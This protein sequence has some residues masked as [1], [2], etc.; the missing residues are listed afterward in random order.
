MGERKCV[1]THII[2]GTQRRVLWDNGVSGLVDN[3]D[4]F[5]NLTPTGRY[6]PEIAA[7]LE[8]MRGEQD[9]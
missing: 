6:F 4:L 8:K 3:T 1:V 7:V 2:D 5:V 9:G